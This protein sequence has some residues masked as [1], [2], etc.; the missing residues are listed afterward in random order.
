[1]LET[2]YAKDSF[3]YCLMGQG[4]KNDPWPKQKL[5][6]GC[7]GKTSASRANIC[8]KYLLGPRDIF[9]SKRSF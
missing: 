9:S 2:P 1:M 6:A 7:R 8:A 5:G 4:R 3:C